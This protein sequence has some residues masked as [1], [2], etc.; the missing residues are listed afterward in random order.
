MNTNHNEKNDNS[1]SVRPNLARRYLASCRKLI[2]QVNRTKQTILAEFRSA[3]GAHE[4]VLRLAL[5]EAE[6]I[7]WQ[8]EYPYLVFPVLA[9]EKAQAAAAWETRQRAV[10]GTYSRRALAV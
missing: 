4:E 8:T 6:A 2:G 1:D 9:T 5:N 7:A 10:Q 3:L